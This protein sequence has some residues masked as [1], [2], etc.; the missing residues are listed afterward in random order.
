[1]NC[2]KCDG[3]ELTAVSIPVEDHSRPGAQNISLDI[4]QC[5]ACG[6]VWFD[7]GELD[8]Y[9]EAGLQAF[10]A[11]A[12]SV[13]AAAALDAKTGRCPRCP[14][15][16]P[17]AH[18]PGRY[19][20]SVTLDACAKCGGTWVDGAELKRAG[21]GELAFGAKMKAFFGDVKPGGR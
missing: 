9:Y 10:P 4:D 18:Q 7:P 3:T 8:K 21:G 2:P 1:M 15:A 14:D 19:D 17:L 16:P 20:P 13:A 6:G 11:P 5:S 12:A